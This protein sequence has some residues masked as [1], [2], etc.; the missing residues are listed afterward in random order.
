MLTLASMK[1]IADNMQNLGAE[2][3]TFSPVYPH[4]LLTE[5]LNKGKVKELPAPPCI[6]HTVCK[7]ID[8]EECSL[9]WF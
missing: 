1:F 6:P 7:A 8:F 3:I 4:C 2:T 9:P 5:K